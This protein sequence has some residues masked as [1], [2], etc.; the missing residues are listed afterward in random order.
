MLDA[1]ENYHTA[2]R[3]YHVALVRLEELTGA[4]LTGE[5]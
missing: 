1:E 4:D 2:L 5:E 3:D